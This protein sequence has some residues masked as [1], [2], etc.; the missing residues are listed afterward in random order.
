MTTVPVEGAVLAWA[1]K[2]RG[3]DEVQAAK[4]LGISVADLADYE[5]ER[6][7]PSVTLF[8][9]FAAKY[10]LPQATL[11]LMAHPVVPPDPNDFRTIGGAKKRTRSFE[12]G[13]ALSN[14]RAWLFQIEK[15]AIDDE[16]FVPPHLPQIVIS[17]DPNIAGERE[18]RR[19]GV[20]V[21]EQFA[22]DRK[23]TFGRWRAHLEKHGVLVFQ[24]KFPMEDGRGFSLYESENAPSVIVN[25]EEPFDVGKTFTIWHEYC[26]LLL[27][28]PGVSDQNFADPTE[29]F[30][31]RFAAA[32]LIPIEAFR[33][34]LP[35]W[36]NQPIDWSNGDVARW[37]MRLKVSQRALA[38]RLE[39]MNL[40]PRG[41]SDKFIA[42]SNARKK[43]TG[44]GNYVATRLSEIG[45]AYTEKLLAALDRRAIDDVQFVEAT[46]L[47]SDH[48]TFAR[49][50]VARGRELV[51]AA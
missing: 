50:Y 32:F 45:L 51:S 15:L 34:L 47:S 38:I 28:N 44:K 43:K 22:W 2:F 36:P 18:R 42:V 48:I 33:E 49:A 14:I 13:V 1:R 16:D 7:Q 5:N 11:F 6:R 31:N 40:A 27:R 3:L 8:E 46:G 19:L 29:A 35:R 9:T 17:D 4:K 24:Q 25:K 21:K 37:A 30:C 26:H 20:T 10:R 23:E 12:F 41:F 39:Q